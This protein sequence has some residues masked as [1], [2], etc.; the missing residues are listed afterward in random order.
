MLELQGKHNIAKVFTDDIESSAISQIINLLNQP[1]V[2]DSKIRMMPDVHAGAGCTIGT[3]MTITDKIVPNLV[4]VDIGCG[5]L[6]LKLN[7]TEIDLKKLDKII[8]KYVPSG[9]SI[10]DHASKYDALDNLIIANCVDINRASKSIGSLGGGNHFIEVDRGEDGRLWLVIH[11]GSRHLGL[12]VCKHYQDLGWN[13][14]KSNGINKKI[15]ETVAKLKAQGKEREIENTIKILKMQSGPIPKELCYVEGK[16]FEDYMHDMKIVQKF[17][18]DNRIAIANI[19]LE[20]TGLSYE[21]CFTTIHNYIDIEHKILRKGAVSARK[22]E[23]LIIPMNMRDGSLICK[24][25]GN[26]DWNQSAPHGSGRIMSRS[27]AKSSVSME[28]YRDSMKDIFTTS[29]NK[30]T[31]DECPMAYKSMQSIIDNIG[32]TVD[33]VDRVKP[34][35]NFKANGD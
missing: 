4:G 25:K 3:T 26:D 12:E 11:T 13:K 22:D 35:Y 21:Y 18:E 14:I 19:I 23:L 8:H 27:Q 1:F 15:K 17:A 33:I 16:D 2:A 32:D 28:D 30:S 10:H 29:V 7:Q 20:H 9:Y 6:A 24:G 31:L 5:M 34:I